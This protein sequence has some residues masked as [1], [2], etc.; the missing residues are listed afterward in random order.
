[1]EEFKLKK[2]QDPTELFDHFVEVNTQYGV[3]APDERKLIAIA[4]KKLPEKYV[5]AFST[6][7]VTNSRNVELDSFEETIESIFRATKSKSN[8][9]DEDEE[10]ELN[11]ASIDAK[12]KKFNKKKKKK[13]KEDGEKCKYCGQV[14]H[15][16]DKC[17]M[18]DKNKNK[19]P[20]WFDPVK[21]NKKK[22]QDSSE[23]G[24]V[25]RSSTGNDGPEMLLSALSFP[26]TLKLL[27]DP[28]IWIADT[29]A[30]CDSTPHDI[31]AENIL[32]G[33]KVTSGIIFGDRKNNVANKIFELPGTVT[34]SS[35][36]ELR[37]VQMKNVLH[38]PTAMFNLFSLT[39]Q[40]KDGWTLHGDK[41]ATWIMKGENKIVFNI[42]IRTSE[43]LVFAVNINR[44]VA[45][46]VNAVG[47]DQKKK[48]VKKI[49]V[50]HAHDTLGH[51]NDKMCRK[52]CATLGWELNRGPLGVCV[53]C[54]V[55]KA[56]QKNISLNTTEKNE[57][58]RKTRIYLD[59][60]SI[61]KPKDIKSITR[62]HC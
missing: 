29:A 23:M 3:T 61:K 44:K 56:K 4:L 20:D 12:K 17:W 9:E 34:D 45:E 30:T 49:T 11:L 38:V 37:E 25:S 48:M 6:L 5:V 55:A 21:Y 10:E 13:T 31:G 50:Q 51:V 52:I 59:I 35:G 40:Q 39:K 46:E 22:N 14:G 36:N 54:T 27:E 42:R 47:T 60:S 57:P 18:L 28:N 58:D 2:G 26:K 53:P 43:G 7:N 8:T 41:Q 24:A 62:R 1:L 16:P 33:D 32:E 15:E 19:R